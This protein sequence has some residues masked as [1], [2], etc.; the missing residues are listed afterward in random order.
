MGW[1]SGP[2]HTPPGKILGVLR[3]GNPALVVKPLNSKELE[4]YLRPIWSQ[5]RELAPVFLRN[6]K[7][8]FFKTQMQ[9]TRD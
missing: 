1:L 9:P 8:G 2:E 7:L 4:R 5:Y 3:I 6:E